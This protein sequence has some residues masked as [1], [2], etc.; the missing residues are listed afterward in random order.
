VLTHGIIVQNA[1]GRW[2]QSNLW[3]AGLPYISF[4]YGTFLTRSGLLD[5]VSVH[6]FASMDKN[7]LVVLRSFLVAASVAYVGLC[8][9][10]AKAVARVTYPN[11]VVHEGLHRES[12]YR[13]GMLLL[14]LLGIVIS[15]GMSWPVITAMRGGQGARVEEWLYHQV[16]VWFFV[17][18]MLLMA[19]TPFI[20][21]RAMG[22]AVLWNRIAN[23]L[24]LSIG[25]T[26]FLFIGIMDQPWGV[27]SQMTETLR[28]PFGGTWPVVPV[29]AALMFLCFFTAVAALWRTIELAGKMKLSV[30]GFIAHAGFALLLGGLILS[31][32]FEKKTRTFVQA[33]S[34]ATALDYSVSFRKLEGKNLFDRDGQA[35]FELTGMGQRPFEMRPGM[36]YYEQGEELKTQVWPAIRSM[37][38][39]DVYMAL[40]PPV[41]DVWEAPQPFRVGE[42]RTI[43]NI[44]VTYESPTM[45]G[46]PGTTG[47]TFGGVFKIESRGEG[48][49]VNPTL[50]LTPQGPQPSMTKAGDEFFVLVGRMDAKD[51]SVDLR[52]MFQRPIYPIELFYKPFT[53]LIWVGTGILTLGGLMAALARRRRRVPVTLPD[54]GGIEVIEPR[55]SGS[56]LHAPFPAPQ[57]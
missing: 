14:A 42:T 36:Y 16:V 11:P 22:R 27:R 2:A 8:L 57:S 52:L 44:K 28:N 46:T 49:T 19:V 33:G 37:P 55:D 53:S 45:T 41:T 32:G 18:L 34:P 51:K 40:F 30:G 48:Y 54:S 1:G 29:V 7:A 47:A 13:F 21:W 23:I 24:S 20:S 15:V 39:H 56:N 35:V 4:L 26:G 50:A 17:P 43:D 31:R 6:S 38:D 12:A 25:L 9:W 10:K 5:N 3:L